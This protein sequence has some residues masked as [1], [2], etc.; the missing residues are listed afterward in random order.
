MSKLIEQPTAN[1]GSRKHYLDTIE[2][3]VILSSFKHLLTKV[4][5][6]L[7]KNI[8]SDEKCYI[9]GVTNGKKNVNLNKFNKIEAGDLTLFAKDKHI[10]STAEVTLKFKNKNLAK[11]LWGLDDKGET[12]ENIYFVNNIKKVN[13][14]YSDYNKAIGNKPNFNI[15]GFNVKDIV[16]SRSVYANL[17][18]LSKPF[19]IISKRIISK[20]DAL[21]QTD[22]E[23]VSKRRLEQ[24][25]LRDFLFEG[26][27]FG[28]CACCHKEYPISFLVT[29]HIKKRSESTDKE[30]KDLNIVMP[31]C[32]FGCDELY[33][34]GYISVVNGKFTPIY[35]QSKKEINK[36]VLDTIK[37]IEN[38]S[39]DYYSKKTSSYFLD[40]LMY[41]TQIKFKDGVNNW[42]QL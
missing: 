17:P 13:I 31:M 24:E 35:T 28:E 8:Y 39:C 19:N 11:L 7:L 20:I 2:N 38:N 21:T 5:I 9:W 1:K 37:L 22:K 27:T 34:N 12:W 29:A 42:E 26:K 10:F 18:A 4:E 30:R 16:K 15:Q 25:F 36:V 23:I 14:P 3:P 32:N 40:H 33:E 6:D 41:H